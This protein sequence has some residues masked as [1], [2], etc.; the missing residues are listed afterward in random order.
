MVKLISSWLSPPVG[1]LTMETPVSL[2]TFNCEIVLDEMIVIWAPDQFLGI[3]S[4]LSL[5]YWL[6]NYDPLTVVWSEA[7]TA[8][9]S[10]QLGAFPSHTQGRHQ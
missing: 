7:G 8:Q 4:R 5:N 2:H 9:E 6:H 10:L 1:I 3:S